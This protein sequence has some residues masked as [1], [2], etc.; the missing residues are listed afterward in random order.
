MI[1]FPACVSLRFTLRSPSRASKP[2]FTSWLT[3]ME[4]VPIVDLRQDA[5]SESLAPGS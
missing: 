1:A 5:K 4:V 3:V 2:R